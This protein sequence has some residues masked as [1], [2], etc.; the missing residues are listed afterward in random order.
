MGAEKSWQQPPLQGKSSSSKSTGVLV[1][2]SAP[3]SMETTPQ[4]ILWSFAQPGTW[5]AGEG[6]ASGGSPGEAGAFH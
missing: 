5:Q 1:S 3:W 6:A 4:G 2:S